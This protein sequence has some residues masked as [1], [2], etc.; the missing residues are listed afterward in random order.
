MDAVLALLSSLL[1]EVPM[2]LLAAMLNGLVGAS[3]RSD[4]SEAWWVL[5]RACRRMF[6]SARMELEVAPPVAAELLLV[7]GER[8]RWVGDV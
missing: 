1:C 5:L 7:L 4:A 2:S 3:R 6:L 8:A